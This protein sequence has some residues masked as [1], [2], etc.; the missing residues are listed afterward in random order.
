MAAAGCCASTAIPAR[1]PTSQF[2]D[3]LDLAAPGDVLVMNDTRV[4]KARL[5]GKKK[6]GGRVEVMVERVLGGGEVLAQIGANH[7]TRAGA[8]LVLA[9]AIEATVLGS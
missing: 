7:P 1:W 9:D 2:R 8:V 6:S 5:L 3:I 4:I